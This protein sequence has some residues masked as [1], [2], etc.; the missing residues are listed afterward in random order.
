[1][2]PKPNEDFIFGLRLTDRESEEYHTWWRLYAVPLV[3]ISRLIKDWMTSI[4]LGVGSDD[5]NAERPAAIRPVQATGPQPI[6]A[7]VD[8]A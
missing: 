5:V 8:V 7:S 4:A 3:K 2:A 1:M 6:A